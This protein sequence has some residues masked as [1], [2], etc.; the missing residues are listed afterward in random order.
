MLKPPPLRTVCVNVEVQ[1]YDA[2]DLFMSNEDLGSIM[3][4]AKD[5]LTG[6]PYGRVGPP[7]PEVILGVEARDA[8]I[9]EREVRERQNASRAPRVD[10]FPLHHRRGDVV[11]DREFLEPEERRIGLVGRSP[12]ILKPAVRLDVV[13]VARIALRNG[14][15]PRRRWRARSMT[16]GVSRPQPGKRAMGPSGG[17]SKGGVKS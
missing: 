10:V 15:G 16:K 5:V 7:E 4:A 13:E 12:R 17:A 3:A 11:P 8:R 14:S 2:D 9:G 6:A 1:T